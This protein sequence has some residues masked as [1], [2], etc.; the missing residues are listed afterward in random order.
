MMTWRVVVQEQTYETNPEE[1]KQWVR[2]GRVLP[3]DQVFQP[4]LGWGAAG[5]IPELQAW[6]PPG[7]TALPLTGGGMGASPYAAPSYPPPAPYAPPPNPYAPA[8]GQVG[9]A[10]LMH[11][12]SLG[13][14]AGLG[15]R[16]LGSVLD[17]FFSALCALPGMLIYVMAIVAGAGQG[18]EVPVGQAAGG[19]LLI[20]IGIIAYLLL[21]AYMTSKSGASP[22]KKIV[23]TVVLR[24]DGEY[25]SFGM[26]ILREFLKGLFNNICILLNLWLLFDSERQQLYD[27]IARAN[28][29]ES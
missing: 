8:Y 10:P 20:Y 16:F 24:E 23:G 6:F 18:G 12:R 1:L 26:A 25:L 27:K 4:G 7:A 2:E 9:Y 29:Y 3:T 13:V 5:Q 19:R 28:V 14:V 15:K 11:A 17:G 22:G 21:S